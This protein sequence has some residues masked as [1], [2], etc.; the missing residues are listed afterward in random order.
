MKADL[1]AKL[2]CIDPQSLGKVAV[3]MGGHSAEREVSLMSGQGVLEALRSKGVDAHAFDTAQHNL[4]ALKEQGFAR[5]FITLHGR[6][7]EDGTVQGALELLGIP[8]TGPGVMASSVAMDK[9]MTKRIWLAEGVSTPRHVE[10]PPGKWQD[11]DVAALIEQLGLPMIIKPPHEGSSIGVFKAMDA[12]GV[13]KALQEV[14]QMDN[15]VLCENL[16]VGEEFT[17]A[18]I[19]TGADV[20]ALPLVRIMAPH[21][22]YDYQN[23]YFGDAVQYACPSGL[24]EQVEHAIQQ[25]AVHA[26]RALG[27]RGWSRIDVMLRASDQMP[28]LL[29]INTSPGMTSHSLVP[30]SARAAGIAYADLCLL[31]LASAALDHA[32]PAQAAKG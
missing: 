3:L 2:Q 21:G 4:F 5:C 7:G 20:Q 14:A 22:E 11:E 6:F 15:A 27:C 12:D 32:L 18:V 29:E 1:Q 23:K 26:Y 13:R 8:Y 19:G 28:F 9:T 24:P 31:I 17:C 30:M 16:I 25:Q 10:L